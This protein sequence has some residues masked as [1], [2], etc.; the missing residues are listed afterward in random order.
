MNFILLITHIL[1]YKWVFC[2]GT[3]QWESTHRF[4]QRV[5]VYLVLITHHDHC[6][7]W[8][9]IMAEHT[10]VVAFDI[11]GTLLDTNS[12]SRSLEK[13]LQLD[14]KSAVEVSALWRRYQL[15]WVTYLLSSTDSNNV[16]VFLTDIL[17]DWIL[18]VSNSSSFSVHWYI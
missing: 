3:C 18:W 8:S 5:C 11:Y 2:D 7:F 17:G 13:H 14:K 4:R 9:P 1:Y 12:I 16:I 6:R 15:E 10:Q